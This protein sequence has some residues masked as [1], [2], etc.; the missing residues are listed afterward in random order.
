MEPILK[1]L[2]EELGAEPSVSDYIIL[3]L[4]SAGGRLSKL[5]IQKGLYILSKHI[6]RLSEVLEF[7]PYRYGPWSPQVG[8]EID[9]LEAMGTVRVVKNEVELADSEAA[10][11]AKIGGEELELVREVGELLKLATDDELL[12]YTYVLYGGDEESDV[13]ERVYSRR[14]DLAISLL[15]KGAVSFTLATRLAGLSPFELMEELK[16]RGIKPF[17]AEREDLDVIN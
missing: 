1:E 12:L 17:V 15:Q 11:R 7:T 6:P 16:R 13:K 8:D 14:I 4:E 9:R 10:R 2:E 3:L 5:K